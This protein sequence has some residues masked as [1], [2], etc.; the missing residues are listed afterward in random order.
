MSARR[1]SETTGR[2]GARVDQRGASRSAACRARRARDS[3]RRSGRA[4][5]CPR[6][7]LEPH[8]RRARGAERGRGEALAELASSASSSRSGDRARTQRVYAR[9]QRV[10]ERLLA[11]TPTSSTS[12]G[13]R[14]IRT[15]AASIA[16]AEVPDI[17]PIQSTRRPLALVR[18]ARAR[19]ASTV[20]A[21]L[22]AHE[23]RDRRGL[24]HRRHA[25][26]A[27]GACCLSSGRMPSEAQAHARARA[28]ACRRS[29]APSAPRRRRDRRA[30]RAARGASRA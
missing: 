10:L 14:P 9:A 23:R 25:A 13:S 16:S 12:L 30:A 17:R 19:R 4:S 27:R 24:A 29:R 18:I 28:R 1:K 22:V 2:P 15:S 20:G 5:R 11:R 7:S 3:A 26:A 8:A 6:T 21:L